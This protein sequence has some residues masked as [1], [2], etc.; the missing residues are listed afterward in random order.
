[1]CVFLVFC[2]NYIYVSFSGLIISFREEKAD[3][4]AIDYS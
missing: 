4:S 1:M 2:F 3:F